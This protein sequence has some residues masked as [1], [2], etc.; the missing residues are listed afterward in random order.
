MVAENQKIGEVLLKGLR[1]KPGQKMPG[2][3]DVR[4]TYD[5]NGLLEV[6]VTIL[7]SGRK[8]AKVFQQR[9][10]TMTED[11]IAE[12]IARLAPI[13]THPR[14]NLQNRS[15]LERANRLYAEL[16]GDLRH[17]LSEL[18]DRFEAALTAQDRDRIS[19]SGEELDSFMAPF[20]TAE[21]EGRE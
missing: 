10:G 17:S 7:S 4:F 14:D 2:T 11:E 13:K 20:F 1:H 16:I 5:M 12:A 3:V 9:P 21:E 18:I 15:R 8:V 19:Q 6:E